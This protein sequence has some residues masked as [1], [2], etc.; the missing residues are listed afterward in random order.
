M[1]ISITSAGLMLGLFA[2]FPAASNWEWRGAAALLDID[3]VRAD[4]RIV[5]TQRAPNVR[6]VPGGEDAAAVTFTVDIEDDV[7]RIRD[8]YPARGLRLDECPPPVDARGDYWRYSAPL[9]V[10]I[11][12][13]RGTRL[14]V[15]VMSGGIRT[16]VASASFD[17]KIR[18]GLVQT[19]P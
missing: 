13:P 9:K 10:T 16:S 1:N 17:L 14:R 11:A 18:D 7:V 6:I 12:V 19:G 4:V 5:T 3:L 15:R 2:P 8:R